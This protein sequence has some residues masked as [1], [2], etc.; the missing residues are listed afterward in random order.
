VHHISISPP[1]L[2]DR[3]RFHSIMVNPALRPS[4]L[5]DEAKLTNCG[6]RENLSLGLGAKTS[7]SD[8]PEA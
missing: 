7:C 6:S 3:L 5:S 8:A 1:P 4:G 2:L